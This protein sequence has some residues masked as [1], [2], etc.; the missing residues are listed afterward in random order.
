MNFTIC[1]GPWNAA[2]ESLF[3]F[4]FVGGGGWGTE[5][6]LGPLGAPRSRASLRF[7]GGFRVCIWDL[8]FGFRA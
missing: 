7:V 3:C 6:G 2:L 4:F 1:I 5:G 8:G